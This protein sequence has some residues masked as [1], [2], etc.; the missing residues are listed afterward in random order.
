MCAIAEALRGGPDEL[1]VK[2]YFTMYLEPV[3]R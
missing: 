1:A 2:P 3:S